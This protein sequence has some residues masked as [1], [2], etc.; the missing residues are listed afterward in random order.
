MANMEPSSSGYV[1]SMRDEQIT[2]AI[3]RRIGDQASDNRHRVRTFR[4]RDGAHRLLHGGRLVGI[5]RVVD[6]QIT[7][8]LGGRGTTYVIPA[9]P[10]HTLTE[11]EIDDAAD[12]I[13]EA[14][15]R[16]S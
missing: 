15:S 14:A 9:I 6:G 3:L 4:Q 10:G 16:G 2:D 1:A 13:C 11:S 12:V 7:L 5:M 8:S